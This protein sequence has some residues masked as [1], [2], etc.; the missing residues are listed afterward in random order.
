MSDNDDEK[1]LNVFKDKIYIF[2]LSICL[3]GIIFPYGAQCILP[4]F[5]TSDELYGLE[6]WNQYV[7]LILGVVATVMSIISLKM[8]FDNVQESRKTEKQTS[9]N[10]HHIDLMLQ[11]ISIQQD[12]QELFWRDNYKST[13]RNFTIRQKDDERDDPP[14][15]WTSEGAVTEDMYQDN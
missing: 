2:L 3:I 10:L 1:K 13:D 8:S 9:D 5:I 14:P 7:G 11:K 6:M 4:F 12:N 15:V